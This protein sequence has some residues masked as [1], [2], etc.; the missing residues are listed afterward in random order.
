MFYVFY[1]IV[2]VI[3]WLPLRV[4]FLLS[5]FFYLIIYYI[6]GYRKKVVRS[7]LK[8]SFPEKS[9]KELINIEKE[10]YRYFC[11]LLVET[12]KQIHITFPEIQKR[13][14]FQNIELL[15]NQY[16]AGKSIFLMTAH[17]GNWELSAS[18][19]LLFPHNKPLYSIYKRLK[20]NSF[21]KFMKTLR[22]SYNGENIEK[23][24]LLRTIIKLK[25]DGKTGTF[26]MISD[27]APRENIAHYYTK[28]L[29]QNTAFLEGTDQLARK[30]DYPV[31][32]LHIDRV[33]R[34]F[35]NC[36]VIPITLAPKTC[37]ENE[38]TEKFVRILEEKI[39]EKPE[40]WLWTHNRWKYSKP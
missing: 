38:I 28:F 6:V 9:A 15:L 11:D 22:K 31:F 2:W 34:G 1:A 21:D 37:V 13:V 20:N 4:L 18:I 17:Y 3:A 27:Q 36:E 19:N 16:K 33:K 40:L 25:N 32:Y 12:I 35:Y 30:F 24:E 7:N 14:R 10:F 5:N 39:N 29:N 26:G 23:K 8:D